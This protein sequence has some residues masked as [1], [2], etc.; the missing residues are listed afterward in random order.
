MNLL[1]RQDAAKGQWR[2]A[3]L[4][5]GVFLVI[6]ALLLLHHKPVEQLLAHVLPTKLPAHQTD[7]RRKLGCHLVSAARRV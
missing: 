3:Y 4:H 1:S 6:E 5:E 2:D 7:V